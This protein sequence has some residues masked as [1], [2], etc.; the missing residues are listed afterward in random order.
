MKDDDRIL[1]DARLDAWPAAEPGPE[2]AD[3]VM[4]ARRAELGGAPARGRWGLSAAGAVAVAAVAV[5]VFALRPARVAAGSLAAAERVEVK[6]GERAVLV[7]ERGA[8]L[9][10]RVE[11]ARAR[12]EQTG[13]DV[14]YRVE[15][16]GPFEVVTPAGVV[17]VKGTC[18]RVEVTDMK[19]GKQALGGAAVG[20]L[21]SAVV[22]VSVYEGKVLLA[23]ERG[24][25]ELKAGERA[26][27]GGGEAPGPATPSVVKVQK[28]VV[29]VAEAPPPA[30]G[31]TREEL[32]VRDAEQRKEIAELRSQ[33]AA[34]QQH[35]EEHG[36]RR[37]Q[38]TK[39]FIKPTKDELLAMAKSCTIQFDTLPLNLE[40]LRF[41]PKM[42]EKLGLSP[43][44]MTVV[45]RVHADVVTRTLAQLR[46]IYAEVTG[47]NTG[48]EDMNGFAIMQA[49][50]EKTGRDEG[51]E[52]R[53]V[54]SQ[55]RAGLLPPPANLA[56]RP[57]A[58]RALRIMQN[59]GDEFERELVK[60]LGDKARALRE[61]EDGWPARGV[62]SGC[63]EDEGEGQPG[64]ATNAE[65]V[66]K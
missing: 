28:P 42:A 9:A 52:A 11:D 23:N 26:T 36:K 1:D 29:K 15:R 53:R 21:A 25:T 64:E 13:G 4:T 22:L 49:I 32:I 7:A 51:T 41:P 37:P 34:L 30:P 47:N 17:T 60:N 40:P 18:F 6:V 35:A 2:F 55:E 39:S 54:L 14:F 31:A 12:V 33:I 8:T 63:Q 61:G 48:A 58:E 59:V 5:L 27:A 38:E 56:V 3:R 62:Q 57:P 50:E 20:A 43:D 44:E 16:G 65:E 46:A 24:A 45:Q 10:W 66:A 19:I